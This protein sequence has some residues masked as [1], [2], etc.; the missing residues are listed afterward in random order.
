M[1]SDHIPVICHVATYRPDPTESKHIPLWLAKSPE[2]AEGLDRL[3]LS[4]PAAAAGSALLAWAIDCMQVAA[5]RARR[6]IKLRQA[7][8][9]EECHHWSMAALRGLRL[10]E[11][12]LIDNAPACYPNLSELIDDTS[13]VCT[14]LNAPCQRA[15]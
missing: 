4:P 14:D 3:F 7:T 9:S 11:V 2:F 10:Q 12:Q 6:H 1:A 13:L 8:T 15:R 5:A